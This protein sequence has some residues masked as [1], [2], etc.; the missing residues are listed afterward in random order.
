MAPEEFYFNDDGTIPNSRLPVLI[1]RDA[2]VDKLDEGAAWLEK[3]FAANNWTNSW[4]NGIYPYHH[5]HSTT[6][7]VLGVYAGSAILKLGGEEG[8]NVSVIAGDVLVIP[9]GVG[10][11]CI[12]N[13][14][15]GIVGAYPDGRDWDV[16]KGEPDERPAADERIAALTVP[17]TDPLWGTTAGVPILWRLDK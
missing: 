2:F 7:E 5:Y 6:H 3:K 9:V 17:L 8:V 14:H 11:K 12:E 13:D 10:H 16:C 1:Y 4:R 15:V